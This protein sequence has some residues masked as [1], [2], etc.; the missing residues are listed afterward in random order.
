MRVIGLDI[1]EK[2]IG[3]AF[4]DTCARVCVPLKVMPAHEV[5]ENSRKWNILLEDNDPELLVCGLPKSLNGKQQ[6][7]AKEIRRAAERIAQ[8]AN[9]PLEF[10][11]ERLSSAEAKRYLREQGLTEREMRGKVDSVAASVFLEAWLS[12]RQAL[13]ADKES[14]R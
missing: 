3:V 14:K 5:Y 4:C 7:Q 10:V 13:G 8:A 11:D 12:S 2:R 6:R 1:G 9:L